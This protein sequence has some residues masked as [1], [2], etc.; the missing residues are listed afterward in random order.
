MKNSQLFLTKKKRKEN[1][2]ILKQE[3]I[4][5]HLYFFNTC[6]DNCYYKK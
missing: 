1:I 4:T 5:I 3:S 2:N 6:Y